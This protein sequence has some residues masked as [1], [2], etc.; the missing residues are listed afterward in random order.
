MET[1]GG[2]YD[3]DS[4]F[5]VRE[6]HPNLGKVLNYYWNAKC[7]FLV[8]ES[9]EGGD[10]LE[11]LCNDDPNDLGEDRAKLIIEQ[12]LDALLHL[13]KVNKFEI[14]LRPENIVFEDTTVSSGVKYVGYGM[15]ELMSSTDILESSQVA[16]LS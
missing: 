7:S 12:I 3:E 11:R 4:R 2:R 5:C 16:K 1:E 15:H 14:N 13:E 8:W 10:L 6:N 9:L